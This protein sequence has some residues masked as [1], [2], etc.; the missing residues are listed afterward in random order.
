M[1]SVF[2]IIGRLSSSDMTV[3]V[4]GESGTGKK[5]WRSLHKHGQKNGP[6]IAI[7]AAAIPQDLLSQSFFG[8]EKGAFTGADSRK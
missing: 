2:R 7:N 3:L 8:H 4:T 6:L 5:L 1:Q